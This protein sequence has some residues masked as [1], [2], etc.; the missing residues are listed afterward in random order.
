V[1]TGASTLLG[2]VLATA[3]FVAAGAP[4]Q[5]PPYTVRDGRVDASTYM[6][7]RVFQARCASCHGA[8]AT[9]TQ[10]APN[11]L[12]RVAAMS[13]AQFVGVVLQRYKLVMPKGETG[14]EGSGLRD[15]WIAEVMSRQQ[16]ELSMPEWS[17]DPAVKPH[18]LD[19]Y[20]YL[21]AR[22]DGVLDARPPRL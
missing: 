14:P 15:A 6:G 16:G 11:L 12:P 21:R 19:I 5:E 17:S 9:G 18:V 4:N 7:W 22:A 10:A 2:A 3:A 1:N 8:A 20:A 13:P